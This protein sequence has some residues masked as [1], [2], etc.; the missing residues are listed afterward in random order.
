M[1]RASRQRV[2]S[3]GHLHGPRSDW[4]TLQ[5]WHSLASLCGLTAGFCHREVPHYLPPT[6]T[7][8]LSYRPNVGIMCP[9][10]LPRILHATEAGTAPSGHGNVHVCSSR[11]T[12]LCYFLFCS[13]HYLTWY[14]NI[15]GVG[16]RCFPE[17]VPILLEYPEQITPLSH[18]CSEQAE[19]ENVHSPFKLL[20]TNTTLDLSRKTKK[21]CS[22]ILNDQLKLIF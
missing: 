1:Q 21:Q 7:R 6:R 2:S 14:W 9:V 11:L 4:A 13:S 3:C 16:T 20:R 17:L 10:T 19:D 22:L 8:L 5:M 18:A 15:I 12:F